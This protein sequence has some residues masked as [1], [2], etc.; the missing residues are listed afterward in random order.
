[1]QL[2]SALRLF[3]EHP[4]L[5]QAKRHPYLGLV[6][7]NRLPFLHEFSLLALVSFVPLFA[8]KNKKTVWYLALIPIS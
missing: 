4:C 5:Y 1:V 8:R 3:A 6:K 2:A 7:G